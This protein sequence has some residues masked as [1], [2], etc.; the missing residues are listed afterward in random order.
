MQ[1]LLDNWIWVLLG[2]GMIAMHL[3]GHGSHGG[4]G[5]SSTEAASAEP[6]PEVTPPAADSAEKRRD[7]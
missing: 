3:F 1:W 2:G 7:F 4:H 5:K 6:P